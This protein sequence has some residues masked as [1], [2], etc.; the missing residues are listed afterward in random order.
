M[1]LAAL[2]VAVSAFLL[3]SIPFGYLL[4]RL[5]RGDDI[6]ARGS[7]NIGATNVLR[8]AG[9]VLGVGTLLLDVV[10]GSAAVLLAE[11]LACRAAH[12]SFVWVRSGS[13]F[14]TPQFTIVAVAEFLVVAGHLYT[15]WL[16]FRGGK[17]VATGLGV[18]LALAPEAALCALALFMLV[19]A[20][21]KYVSVA[22][23]V[24]AGLLPLLL[25]LWRPGFPASVAIAT[26]I[27]SLL[28][29]WRHAPNLRRLRLGTEPKL[30]A[31]PA[32][33]PA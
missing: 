14:T 15:P 12:Q 4:V 22:S 32:G 20:V 2:I 9:K 26:A 23:M 31:R 25:V 6:R 3:G 28:V 16:G 5:R 17:G 18:M 7:G 1:L 30:G 24:S 33:S 11:W 29:I 8:S 10:K 19:V 21:W 13:E 27:I